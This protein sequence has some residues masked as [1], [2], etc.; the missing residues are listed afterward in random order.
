[1]RRPTSG[2]SDRPLPRG[3]MVT[4]VNDRAR[5]GTWAF[6]AREFTIGSVG[7]KTSAGSPWPN[8]S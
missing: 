7:A 1:M 4:T 8:T 3:S 2:R 5:Y 6:Q